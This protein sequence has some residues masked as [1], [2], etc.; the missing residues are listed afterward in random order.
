MFVDLFLFCIFQ[1]IYLQKASKLV[2]F[3]PYVIIHLSSYLVYFHVFV[4]PSLPLPVTQA[5]PLI[6]RGCESSLVW[7]A[8]SFHT[9]TA[10]DTVSAKMKEGTV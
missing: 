3:Y 6:C 4:A 9:K 8:L 10:T 7:L 5:L 1:L 2:L